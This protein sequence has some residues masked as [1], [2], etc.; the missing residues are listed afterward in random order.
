MRS[1]SS[2]FLP[3]VETKAGT[4]LGVYLFSLRFLTTQTSHGFEDNFVSALWG[5]KM[6]LSHPLIQMATKI[7]PGSCKEEN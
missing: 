6:P 4:L 3:N 5:D 1:A 2:G 7:S